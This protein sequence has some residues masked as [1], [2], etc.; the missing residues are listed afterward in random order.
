MQSLK[1]LP[2]GFGAHTPVLQATGLP[3]GA[4]PRTGID[5]EGGTTTGVSGE[6]PHEPPATWEN[7]SMKSACT[8]T[9]WQA[10]AALSC[11]QVV[12]TGA[13]AQAI[14]LPHVDVA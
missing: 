6:A 11:E 9:P 12:V 4:Q 8:V 1:A 13:L 2:A 5:H 7:V 10:V 3:V 14:V